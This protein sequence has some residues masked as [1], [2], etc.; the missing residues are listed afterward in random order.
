M[1]C[2]HV[3]NQNKSLPGHLVSFIKVNQLKIDTS[4][5]PAVSSEENPA[6]EGQE[7]DDGL[8]GPS[9]FLSINFD[10]NKVLFQFALYFATLTVEIPL[11]SHNFQSPFSGLI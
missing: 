10:W 5:P 9:L 11:P 1:Q 4:R 3:V 2:I 8:Y 7:D 6:A